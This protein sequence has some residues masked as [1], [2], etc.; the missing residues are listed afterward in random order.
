MASGAAGADRA[1]SLP[2]PREKG[3]LNSLDKFALNRQ[4]NIKNPVYQDESWYSEKSPQYQGEGSPLT[5]SQGEVSAPREKATIN[6]KVKNL[7]TVYG[8]KKGSKRAAEPIEGGKGDT[9]RQQGGFLNPKVFTGTG[10]LP[11][12]PATSSRGFQLAASLSLSALRPGPS[13]GARSSFANMVEAELECATEGTPFAPR[14]PEP[15]NASFGA[16][17]DQTLRPEPV[18]RSYIKQESAAKI[19][20]VS[21]WTSASLGEKLRWMPTVYKPPEL[22]VQDEV[23]EYD[24][25]DEESWLREV[26]SGSTLKRAPK[27]RAG[28]KHKAKPKERPPTPD[29]RDIAARLARERSEQIKRHMLIENAEYMDHQ[30]SDLRR[31]KVHLKN[32]MATCTSNE[33]FENRSF[34]TSYAMTIRQNS[35][36]K[37]KRAQPTFSSQPLAK[38]ERPALNPS[39]RSPSVSPTHKSVTFMPNENEPNHLRPPPAAG[40]TSPSSA[41]STSLLPPIEEPTGRRKRGEPEP[42]TIARQVRALQKAIE[43]SHKILPPRL[44]S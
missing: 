26:A 41:A 9:W 6:T 10:Q 2:P 24:H 13:L 18:K 1:L 31:G 12:V 17:P 30:L 35:D 38:E 11:R 7:C 36:I 25:D 44:S 39:H 42:C 28:E 29:A 43:S 27:A 14:L 19:A 5:Q 23:E 33:L 3:A 22:A 32:R 34:Y 37:Q 20:G 4:I 15:W 21:P 16:P 40:S 8:V